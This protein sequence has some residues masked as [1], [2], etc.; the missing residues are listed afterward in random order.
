VFSSGATPTTLPSPLVIFGTAATDNLYGSDQD[1]RL[2]GGDSIDKLDGKGGDDYLEG[3]SGEDT[4]QFS[5]DWGN[6]TILDSDGRGSIQID[7]ATLSGGQQLSASVWLSSNRQYEFHFQASA[8]GS[9]AGAGTGTG[10]GTGTLRIYRAGRFDGRNAITVQGWKEG[11]LGISL[12]SARIAPTALPNGAG[13]TSISNTGDQVSNAVHTSAGGEQTYL[14]R[15]GDSL[16]PQPGHADVLRASYYAQDDSLGPLLQSQ[17]RPALAP[18]YTARGLGG[19]DALLGAEGNDD[20]DGGDG[21]DIVSGGAGSDRLRGG[22]GNDIILADALNAAGWITNQDRVVVQP[23]ATPP[24]IEAAQ[25][26]SSSVAGWISYRAADGSLRMATG[27]ESA[28]SYDNQLIIINHHNPLAYDNDGANPWSALTPE[29]G[30]DID[31]G[32]GNDMVVGGF[33]SDSIALGD[34][35]D[36]AF[37]GSGHDDIT[38]GAGN[39]H[40]YGDRLSYQ[41]STTAAGGLALFG[42]DYIDGGEGDDVIYGDDGD[43]TLLGGDGDDVLVG[44]Y[45]S[46]NR[47]NADSQLVDLAGDTWGALAANSGGDDRLD[48]GAG[49]DSLSGG[50]GDDML[51]GGS[52]DDSLSGGEGDDTL[53]G[54]SGDDFLDGGAGDDYMD[55][56]SGNDVLVGGGGNDTLVADGAPTGVGGGAGG[57]GTAPSS[58]M[59]LGGE[60]DD[61][62]LIGSN[63]ARVVINLDLGTSGGVGGAGAGTGIGTMGRD[64][65]VIASAGGNRHHTARSDGTD[66][67]LE[68]TETADDGTGT[69]G[70]KAKIRTI[71]V[72]RYFAGSAQADVAPA[73]FVSDIA[74]SLADIS[75]DDGTVLTAQAI[76]AAALAGTARDDVIYG[77]VLDDT[78]D[79]LQGNDKVYGANGNDTISG[80]DGD[81]LL[82]GGA[83]DDIL[84]GGDGNDTLVGGAGNDRLQGGAGD[85]VYVISGK[86]EQLTGDGYVIQNSSLTQTDVVVDVGGA[87]TI[88]LDAD[89]VLASLVAVRNK[90]AQ[91][92]DQIELSYRGGVVLVQGGS[93]VAARMQV[94][95]GSTRFSL[96]SLLLPDPAQPDPQTNLAAA[97]QA[98]IGGYTQQVRRNAAAAASR[99]WMD[100]WA[101]RPDTALWNTVAGDGASLDL[102][103]LDTQTTLAAVYGNVAVG[104][105]DVLGVRY[106]SNQGTLSVQGVLASDSNIEKYLTPGETVVR[107]SFVNGKLL[108]VTLV[109]TP[110][111]PTTKVRF[112]PVTTTSDGPGVP[113]TYTDRVPVYESRIVGYDS[114]TT[115]VQPFY[116]ADVTLGGAGTVLTTLP[117]LV[118][119]GAGDDTVRVNFSL[120][121]V[122]EVSSPEW[123]YIVNSSGPYPMRGANGTMLSAAFPT[124]FVDAG[125]GDD[126]VIGADA[127]S[128]VLLGGSGRNVL[129]GGTGSDHY[130]VLDDGG[131]AQEFDVIEDRSITS[132]DSTFWD[133]YGGSGSFVPADSDIDTVVFGPGIRLDDLDFKVVSAVSDADIFSGFRSLPDDHGA[134]YLLVARNG[135]RLAAIDLDTFTPPAW[136]DEPNYAGVPARRHAPS[137]QS[138][139]EFLEFADHSHI[140]LAQ[141]VALA[142]A[143][144]ADLPMLAAGVADVALVGSQIFSI[145]IPA[146]AFSDR[147]AR[148]LTYTLESADGGALPTWLSVVRTVT[149]T[150]VEW[151]LAGRAEAVALTK[152]LNVRVR[153]TSSNGASVTDDVRLV[154]S[155]PVQT[156]TSDVDY[157]E[158]T[159]GADVLVGLDGGDVYVVN[160]ANDH[161]VELPGEGRDSVVASVSYVLPDNVE[162][163]ELAGPLALIATG[164]AM[165]NELVGN[166]LDNSLYGLEGDDWLAGGAGNDKLYGGAGVDTYYFALG[167]GDDVIMDAGGEALRIVL[168]A[169]AEG[170]TILPQNITAQALANGAGYLL[171]FSATDS[172]TVQNSGAQP[173]VASNV[174]ITLADGTNVSLASL[175]PP[176]QVNHAPTV[177]TALDAQSASEDGAWSFTVP[178]GT[179]IDPDA[180]DALTLSATQANGDDLPA[181]L[182]FDAETGIFSGKPLNADVGPLSIQVTATD[183]GGLSASSTFVVE[184]TKPNDAPTVA[185]A[186]AAQTTNEDS[187]WRFTVPAG[188]FADQDVGDTV[189][190]TAKL[191]NGN[192]LPSWL[193]F[194]ALTRTFS[195]TPLNANVGAL[196]IQVTATD[197]GGLSVSSN[198]NV[199]VTNTNDAPVVRTA[200]TN[201]SVVSGAAFSYTVPITGATATFADEDVGDV[202]TLTVKLANGSALPDWLSF[203]AATGVFSGTPTAT[204]NVSVQV[205]ATDRAGA[206]VSSSFALAVLPVPDATAPTLT[207]AS[208][209]DEATAVARGANLVLTF[210]EAIKAGT[211]T[212]RITNA[213]TPTDTRTITVTDATQV[214]I[215]GNVLTLNPTLDLLAGASYSVQLTA[216]AVLDL[217]GNAYAGIA[218]TTALNFTTLP[219]TPTYTGQMV[220]TGSKDVLTADSAHHVVLGLGGNDTLNGFA[221]S[222]HLVGGAGNDTINAIGGAANILDGGEGNDT[223]N[224]SWGNDVIDAGDGNNEVNAAGG[225]NNIVAGEGNDHISADGGDDVINAGD[226]NNWVSAGAGRNVLVTGE[227]N[228]TITASGTNIVMAGA[229]NDQ[230]A[231][232]A[233]NDWVQAGQGN[234]LIDAGGGNNLFAF[235]KG[236]GK[237]T[238]VNSRGGMDTISLGGGLSYANL[239]LAK[240]GND[241]VLMGAKGDQITLKDWYLSVQNHGVGT[242]QVLTTG[243]DYDAASSNPLRNRATV[244]L[245]FDKLVKAFDAARL[246]SPSAASGWALSSSL[247][248][249]QLYAGAP[250]AP[251]YINPWVALQAGTA[252]MENAPS[253]AMNP[254][255][256]SAQAVD[257]LLFAAL[258]A[259]ANTNPAKGWMQA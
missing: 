148:E 215:V 150:G 114:V 69:G 237:D 208:P 18:N 13:R 105:K 199:A 86:V 21:D 209:A 55:G 178:E 3:G 77:T 10:T 143:H 67:R 157:L 218:N 51:L 207:S 181:W 113:V 172:L 246:A 173:F 249:A 63:A 184:V 128:D 31:A 120:D 256:T 47:Q 242:L 56:D 259:T 210:S 58:S 115:S 252:L 84:R 151:S 126:H 79:A 116:L 177:A 54:G 112:F 131:S 155:V 45:D 140:T 217:T 200:L 1:D 4:Y 78:V 104:Y 230:I 33:G 108:L 223:I 71:V 228:D 236:D 255:S 253:I 102:T 206:A 149:P 16:V 119:V 109:M 68:V 160:H 152:A 147:F 163:L 233:G 74:A 88:R 132:W 83:G 127:G 28:G 133:I 46:Q 194:D 196:A 122:P 201:Q 139:V 70:T 7:G 87:D 175:L 94:E 241:L 111:G 167:D 62:Y 60:G 235:N 174:E 64:R 247:G 73:G 166:A 42:S 81:D 153:A 80:G 23:L 165:D 170:Q 41:V 231:L 9:G 57:G 142:A 50:M 65:I 254:I 89:T 169:G 8:A 257:Q 15:A 161:V 92:G 168:G 146:G 20:L 219:A 182:S 37:G 188:T 192:P 183:T 171:Q 198:L 2:Y 234:D 35:D 187:V 66:L 49:A 30:N 245:D 53:M 216:G 75:F 90:N 244:M 43:D 136:W 240:A 195:G 124:T 5:G 123:V 125:A 238:V 211:G 129:Q 59:L 135:R 93:D 204:G 176:T 26:I 243:G 224:G 72:Q 137:A 258:N 138:G 134:G 154:V 22:A 141:A 95:V 100:G 6:D 17:V 226:G 118:S 179:F 96:G 91:G 48:G 29:Y 197:S 205:T 39:D 97:N 203:N 159:S 212:L 106:V 239:K 222:T 121:S 36:I 110:E 162:G 82:D 220:G 145:P 130:L 61:T 221:E 250:I 52:G 40:I 14:Y 232:G 214:S 248:A 117:G 186:L 185:T 24:G 156:G 32:S 76:V 189:V 107:S 101:T 103:T 227:G 202:L 213:N 164:N 180:G 34:G 251:G 229:G 158:G 144:S 85:D 11:G 44:D 98:F 38:G 25:R 12:N 190:L 193:S 191:A 225:N 27:Q 19:N 99:G